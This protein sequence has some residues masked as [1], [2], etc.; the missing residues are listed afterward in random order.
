[1]RST[2]MFLV[3]TISSPPGD[4]IAWNTWRATS[5]H[6]AHVTGRTSASM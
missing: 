3:S 1:M 2:K 6:S 5:G 4:R